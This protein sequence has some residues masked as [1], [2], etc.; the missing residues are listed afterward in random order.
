MDRLRFV[1]SRRRDT[2][3][4]RWIYSAQGL[5]C[6]KRLQPRSETMAVDAGSRP[7]RFSPQE[8]GTMFKK[9]LLPTDGSPVSRKAV[10]QGVAFA[11]SIG[12]QRSWAS[13]RPRTTAC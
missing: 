9:I 6:V 3:G 11:K 10:K 1:K 5:I 4:G 8:G 12:A 13:S 7:G 2:R